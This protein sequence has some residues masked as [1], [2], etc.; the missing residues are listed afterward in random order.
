MKWILRVKRR[1]LQSGIK[2][3]TSQGAL[4]LHEKRS[5]TKLRLRRR[6][7]ASPTNLPP[8]ASSD[9]WQLRT[10]AFQGPCAVTYFIPDCSLLRFTDIVDEWVAL[11]EGNFL[12]FVKNTIDKIV[13]SVYNNTL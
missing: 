6:R 3:V 10:D 13:W 2:Y 7:L 9:A 12:R 5:S 4:S 1:R 8:A 11:F